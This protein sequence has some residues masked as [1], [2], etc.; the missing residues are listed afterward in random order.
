M[1]ILLAHASLALYAWPPPAIMIEVKGYG[2]N[3][4]DTWPRW[5]KGL[6]VMAKL[7]MVS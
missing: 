5:V 4:C 7:E 3:L 2:M 6:F 1:I